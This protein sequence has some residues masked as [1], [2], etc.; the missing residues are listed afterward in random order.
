MLSLDKVE[1]YAWQILVAFVI[2]LPPIIITTAKDKIIWIV[3][4]T[5]LI[6]IFGTILSI[7]KR[8]IE[9]FKE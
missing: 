6:L 2:G 3:I 1:K 7:I 8:I 5:L 9:I 4:Y